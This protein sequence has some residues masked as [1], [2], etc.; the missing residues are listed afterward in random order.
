MI[1]VLMSPGGVSTWL[2][3]LL[4]LANLAMLFWRFREGGWPWQ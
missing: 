2:V 1:E 4:T 3:V